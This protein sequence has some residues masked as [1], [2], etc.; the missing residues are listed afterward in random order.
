MS[1]FDGQTVVV[2]GAASGIGF[3]MARLFAEQ[4]AAFV[5]AADLRT[6]NAPSGTVA[7][8]VDVADEASVAAMVADV[9]ERTGRVDVLCNNAG[10]GS[11]ADPISCTVEEWDRVFAV[12]A[13][14]VFLGTK[15]VLPGMLE[16]RPADRS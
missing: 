13:R 4:G 7:M 14:G 5:G 10:V 8:R 9:V 12:N 11:T 1:R 2:T 16:R 3:E 6:E 15:H